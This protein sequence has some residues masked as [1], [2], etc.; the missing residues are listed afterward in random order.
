MGAICRCGPQKT[1]ENF[2][3]LVLENKKRW[4]SNGIYVSF[5]IEIEKSLISDIVLIYKTLYI[6]FLCQQISGSSFS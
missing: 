5:N 6:Y 3:V 2:G 1:A 4:D